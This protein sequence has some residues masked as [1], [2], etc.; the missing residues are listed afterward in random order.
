MVHKRKRLP[1]TLYISE[2]EKKRIDRALELYGND[3]GIWLSRN[4]FIV[5]C[6]IAKAKRVHL[7]HAKHRKAIPLEDSSRDDIEMP[8]KNCKPSQLF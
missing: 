4:N 8:A 6:A 3:S 1:L 5:G 2:S 7:D